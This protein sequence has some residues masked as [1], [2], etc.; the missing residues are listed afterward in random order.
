MTETTDIETEKQSRKPL[1]SKT[2]S[3]PTI[4]GEASTPSDVHHND[5][6]TIIIIEP[7]VGQTSTLIATKKIKKIVITTSNSFSWKEGYKLSLA[8]SIVT[9]IVSFAVTKVFPSNSQEDDIINSAL[10]GFVAGAV[11]AGANAFAHGVHILCDATTSKKVS[12]QGESLVPSKRCNN[13]SA[14]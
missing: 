2:G 8:F 14:I 4:S 9:F 13:W 3:K 6:T 12:E 7:I 5:D 11:L 1:L 10:F